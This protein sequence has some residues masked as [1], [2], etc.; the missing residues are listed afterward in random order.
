MKSVAH[1]NSAL[2]DVVGVSVS[3][4][5]SKQP[6]SQLVTNAGEDIQ[7]MKIFIHDRTIDKIV[8]RSLLI[9]DKQEEENIRTYIFVCL[10]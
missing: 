2:N 3:N 8:H 6:R 10:V 5:T 9:R 7:I 4:F 1:V